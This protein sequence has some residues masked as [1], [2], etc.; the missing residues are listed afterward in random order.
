MDNLVALLREWRMQESSEWVLPWGH[1][2][3]RLYD[4]WKALL[5][6]AG[7]TGIQFK[8]FRSSAASQILLS[9]GSTM[10]ARDLLGHSNITTLE[11]HYA[12]VSTGLRAAME[13]RQRQNGL[14]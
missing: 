11:K 4:D 7:V 12:N 1:A 8:H 5:S 9:G 14:D 3:R 2:P 13:A 6:A 10:M